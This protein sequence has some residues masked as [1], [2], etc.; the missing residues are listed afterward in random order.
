MRRVKLTSAVKMDAPF[1]IVGDQNAVLVLDEARAAF[2][3]VNKLGV[4]EGDPFDIGPT[5][6]ELEAEEARIH[7]VP[8]V[9]REDGD[10]IPDKP[11]VIDPADLTSDPEAHEPKRPYGNAPKSAWI[12][13]AVAMSGKK[14]CPVITEERAEEMSKADLMSR[15]G[16][17]LL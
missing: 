10:L 14:G 8:I 15:Y 1:I 4:Y 3:V 16:E 9:K 13:Y 17:R 12:R 5:R 6:A 11:T 7:R 2:L